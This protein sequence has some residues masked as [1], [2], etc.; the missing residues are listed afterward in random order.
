ML[1]PQTVAAWRRECRLAYVGGQGAP[2]GNES[3]EGIPLAVQQDASKVQDVFGAVSTPAHARCGVGD[4][5]SDVVVHREAELGVDFQ[6]DAVVGAR[7]R[8]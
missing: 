7:L 5:A 8:S 4:S 2:S 3:S 1:P 6:T